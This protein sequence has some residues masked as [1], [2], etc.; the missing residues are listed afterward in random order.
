MK[1][2]RWMIP[3]IWKATIFVNTKSLIRAKELVSSCSMQTL[4]FEDLGFKI[5]EAE[6]AKLY[7]KETSN[8]SESK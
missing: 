1:S 7:P 8:E 6:L 4:T 3:V 2:K 5:D